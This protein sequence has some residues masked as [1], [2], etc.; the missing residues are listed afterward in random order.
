[1]KTLYVSL[2]SVIKLFLVTLAATSISVGHWV[3]IFTPKITVFNANSA[4]FAPERVE[5]IE[6]AL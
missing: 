6:A 4:L 2:H 3:L 1:M 5:L